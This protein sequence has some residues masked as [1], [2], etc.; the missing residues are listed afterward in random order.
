MGY[1]SAGTT[2][3]PRS[4]RR[5]CCRFAPVP[6]MTA[7][8]LLSEAG[9]AAAFAG[10]L[11]AVLPLGLAFTASG[12]AYAGW[13][14]YRYAAERRELARRLDAAL[15]HEAGLAER[16]RCAEEEACRQRG[17]MEAAAAV[18]HETGL[19]N[20]RLYAVLLQKAWAYGRRNNVPVS[21]VAV[22]MDYYP[23][24][25]E[26]KGSARAAECLHKLARVLGGACRR[27][28][29][30]CAHLGGPEFALI[31]PDT[32]ADG[33]AV[34][35]CRMRYELEKAGILNPRSGTGMYV[36]V[37]SGTA[38]ALPMTEHS[39]EGLEQEAVDRLHAAR[40]L[41]GNGSVPGLQ[42]P[43]R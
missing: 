11:T 13:L 16:L 9:Q 7:V 21:L 6:V 28:M 12:A 38:T 15:H 26:T 25:L 24:L 40:Q 1:L 4:G 31:L 5:V 23:E 14:A 37:S 32:A 27:P 34:V 3:R 20:K 29:D 17:I 36:T 39:S 33:A 43:T 22:C 2:G 8:W 30:V 10:G 35:V 18:E 19:P 42:C 41:G